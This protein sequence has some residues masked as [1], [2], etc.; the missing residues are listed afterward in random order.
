[1]DFLIDLLGRF[2]PLIVHLPI[3]FLLLGLMMLVFDR[4]ESKHLN[5]IRFTFFWG[6]FST[7]IAIFTGTIQHIR[8]GYLWEDVQG[9]LIFGVFTF[10]LSFLIYIK[11][12]GYGLFQGLSHH[13]LG[14]GL[15]VVL[16]ITGHL[17]GNLT[18]GK[19]H[20]T[21]PLPSGLKEALG[22]KVPSQ[23]LVLLPDTYQELPLYSGVIKPILD[24]KCVSCHNPKKTKGA[25]LLHNYK[26]IINGGEEGP[27][28]S[29][30][31]PEK[32]EILKRIHLPKEEKKHMPPK[33]KTQLSKAEI[34][35]IGQW[36]NLGAPENATISDLNLS[37][38]LFASFFPKDETSIYPETGLK[39]LNKV[40]LDSLIKMGLQ[41]TPIYK[42]SSQL[43]ISTINVPDFNDKN[44]ALLLTVLDH[45]VDLD[46]G[47][48]RVT[49][50]IFD[51]LQ[52]LKY[53]TVL[54]LNRTT[55][56]GSGINKLKSL[57]HLKQ[58][59]LVNS[60]FDGIYLEDLYSFP[61]LEKVYLFGTSSNTIFIEIPKPY[62]TI[63]ERGNYKLDE[64]VE[65][66]L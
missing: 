41:V 51:V 61:A 13:F 27:I 1:M 14:Y 57:Q 21:A 6:T 59:N 40:L 9:H 55:I 39:P 30:V 15:F 5:I 7:L 62:Q 8:E 54:K 4:K 46:L 52:Q 31:S 24:Q 43:R 49:D 42:T 28:I 58:I 56:S 19:D 26:G 37:Q 35:L 20:L 47:Q 45:I 17:G 22:M 44:A 11:L 10:I 48:T 18:H 60:N 53:L 3:G 38:G 33:A 65:E 2:H 64:E 66:T 25:L 23:N 29:R 50:T 32:S 12:K 36:I 16:L 63:F 34:K